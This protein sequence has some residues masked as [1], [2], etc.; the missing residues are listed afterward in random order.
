MDA[1]SFVISVLLE[2]PATN[3]CCLLRH[4][5]FSCQLFLLAL[6]CLWK[7]EGKACWGQH[8]AYTL[9]SG[10]D[11]GSRTVRLKIPMAILFKAAPPYMVII[12]V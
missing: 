11:R 6:L 8:A 2:L 5:S 7:E 9:S 4:N 3:Y 1:F 10:K 12:Q